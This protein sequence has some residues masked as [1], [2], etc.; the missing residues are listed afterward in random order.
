TG[1]ELI[2]AD[3][4]ERIEQDM[5]GREGADD[6]QAVFDAMNEGRAPGSEQGAGGRMTRALSRG[7]LGP[8]GRALSKLE[9]AQRALL[10]AAGGPVAAPYLR[11]DLR[12]SVAA[13]AGTLLVLPLAALA[14]IIL[15]LV[16]LTQ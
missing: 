6:V 10:T 12:V 15:A 3:L 2:P 13:M 5:H 16:L 8:I 9:R 11:D 7:R 4:T 14:A 1:Q